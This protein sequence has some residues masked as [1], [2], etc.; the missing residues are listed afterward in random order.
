MGDCL[1][2]N[3]YCFRFAANI[4]VDETT[5]GASEIDAGDDAEAVVDKAAVDCEYSVS[6]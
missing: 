2:R 3:V 4:H 5:A 6:S 1:F